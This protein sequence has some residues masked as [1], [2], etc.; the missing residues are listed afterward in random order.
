MKDYVLVL[1]QSAWS[2]SKVLLPLLFGG[3]PP[4]RDPGVGDWRTVVDATSQGW[5]DLG[6]AYSV[7]ESTPQYP[8]T[9]IPIQCEVRASIG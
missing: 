3:V 9:F 2:Y 7:V 4:W 5:G 8:Y 6:L 1:T